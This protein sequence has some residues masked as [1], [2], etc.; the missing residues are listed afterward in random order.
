MKIDR[1]LLLQWLTHYHQMMS[2]HTEAML[3]HSKLVR[4]CETQQRELGKLNKKVVEQCQEIDQLREQMDLPPKKAVSK[5]A[6][7][8][9][10]RRE[11]RTQRAQYEDIVMQM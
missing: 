9:Q 8:R 7:R 10:A 6:R 11:A 2:A 4:R 5:R 3:R 1:I